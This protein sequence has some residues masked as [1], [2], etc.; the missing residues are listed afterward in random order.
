MTNRE[1][2]QI[3]AASILTEADFL[4]QIGN[5]GEYENTESFFKSFVK[6]QGD[7]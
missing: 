2:L 3:P 6:P 1:K 7:S 4:K 5:I